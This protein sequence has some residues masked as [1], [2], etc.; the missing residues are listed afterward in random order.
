MKKNIACALSAV[1]L[2]CGC[3]AA[4]TQTGSDIATTV[5]IVEVDISATAEEAAALEKMYEG[6][7]A[8]HGDLHV[9]TQSGEKSDGKLPLDKWSGAMEATKVDFAVVADHRQT[10]HY[11]HEAWDD[12]IFIFASEG[13]M[14]IPSV[15]PSILEPQSNHTNYIFPTREAMEGMLQAFPLYFNFNSYN[16]TYLDWGC[17]NLFSRETAAELIKYIQDHGGF[18]VLLHPASPNATEGPKSGELMDFW[19]VDGTGFEVFIGWNGPSE[20]YDQTKDG[21]ELWKQLLAAGKKIYATA[22]SDTHGNPKND[23]MSTIY[24]TEKNAQNY[25]DCLRAGDF[26]PSPMGVRMVI[27]DTRMGGTTSFQGKKVIFSVGDFHSY[28][29][30]KRAN[31][32]AVLVSDQGTVTSQNFTADETVYF[33]VD[34]EADAKYYYVE[35]YDADKDLLIGLGNPI[36]NAES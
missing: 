1:M 33:S 2:L 32:C 8:Y 29:T 25:I 19:L 16:G 18:F 14:R 17:G 36:W 30:D 22:G 12:S 10:T 20:L 23:A 15:N 27:G 11:D 26:S 6:R 31:F 35:I 9:H 3:Q 21:Y 13:G 5:P 24:V 7:V 34:A 28:V 4:P